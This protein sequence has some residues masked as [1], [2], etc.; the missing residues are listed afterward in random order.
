MK[1]KRKS[2]R[3]KQEPATPSAGQVDSPPPKKT[4]ALPV[5]PPVSAGDDIY[6]HA[7]Y[8]K[9]YTSDGAPPYKLPPTPVELLAFATAIHG[10]GPLPKNHTALK[11]LFYQAFVLWRKSQYQIAMYSKHFL[12]NQDQMLPVLTHDDLEPQK[13][14]SFEHFVRVFTD[15][16]RS[17]DARRLF[18][19]WL[20]SKKPGDPQKKIEYWKRKVADGSMSRMFLDCEKAKFSPW[21]IRHRRTTG[22]NS[23]VLRECYKVVRRVT[24]LK[25][26]VK[27]REV[28]QRW[29]THETEAENGMLEGAALLEHTNKSFEPWW[30]KD[31]A[32]KANVEGAGKP[33]RRSQ[34]SGKKFLVQE[35]AQ[36]P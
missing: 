32:A 7:P 35:I 25:G 10:S 23:V 28:F 8:L 29:A 5:E 15:S 12:P 26:N 11:E 30:N 18:Q 19:K 22:T 31:Q 6:A 20:N 27:V 4:P 2:P 1:E 9:I 17:D 34:K 21:H 16:S 36:G 13:F 3:N 33:S 14:K 24:G